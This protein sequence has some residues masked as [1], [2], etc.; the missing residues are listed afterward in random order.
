MT[1]SFP[2]PLSGNYS[3][4]R[5]GTEEALAD[6][7]KYQAVDW[8]MVR[9]GYFEMMRTPVLEGRTFTEADNDPKRNLVV[10]DQFL[11]AKAFP[12]QSAVGKRILIRVRTPEPEFVAIIGVVAHQRF[13]SLA[14]PG[15]EQVFITDGFM[16]FGAPRWAIRAS[17][18]P[19]S[20][21]ASVRA[22]MA[23]FDPTI[24]VADVEPMT[25]LV[26]RAQA[27]TRFTLV[28]IA[29]FAVIAALLVAVGLYGV[30]S[31]IVRQRTAEIGVRMA[32]GAEPSSI[33]RM[34]VG[35]GL[36]LSVA[37]VGVGLISASALTRV[38]SALL[39]GV[40]ATDPLT[41]GTVAVVFFAIAALS[42]WLPAR[43]AAALD[44]TIALRE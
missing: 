4:I 24:L 23:R 31:T 9:P 6:N 29:V 12:G 11:A 39:V 14:D 2:F 35:E 15:R 18:D 7:T 13:V 27:A 10:V 1:T 42:S 22:E 44:P 38:M 30:L 3:T 17:G 20:L 34:V 19:A 25:T 16:G 32:L 43:R 40:R 28:L 21:A 41:F 33:R 36:R 37:G 26:W 8:Q 5:W